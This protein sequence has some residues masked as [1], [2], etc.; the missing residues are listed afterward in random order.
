M[1]LVLE[2]LPLL[3]KTSSDWHQCAL[4]RFDEFLVDHAACERK[5]S[6]L[7]MSFVVKYADRPALVEPMICLAKE[8]LAHFHEVYR[9]MNRRGLQLGHDEKD[10]YLKALLKKV[11]NGR[12]EHFLDRL[13]V[14]GIVEARG[15][16][17]FYL[18]GEF[19]DDLEMAEFYR[20][21]AREEAGHHAIFINIAKHYFPEDEVEARNQF[22]LESEAEILS[23]LE[24]RP[25]VH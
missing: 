6:A 3:S 21:L 22:W 20:R 17:R 25:A 19:H 23:K 14:S 4:S 15:C 1:T 12:E 7:A 13:L 10:P 8:E 2:N 9:I 11:R 18:I 24:I 16:E 5:A